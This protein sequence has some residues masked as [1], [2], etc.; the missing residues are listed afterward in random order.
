MYTRKNIASQNCKERSK[1]NSYILNLN[2]ENGEYGY[3]ICLNT[4]SKFYFDMED[5]DLIKQYCWSEHILANGYHRI[6]ARKKGTKENIKF[7]ELIGCKNYDHIDRNTLNN[8]KYNLRLYEKSQNNM[9]RSLN[10]NN[11]S[12][13]IGVCWDKNNKKW[14][15]RIGINYKNKLLGSYCNKEE[16]IKARLKAEKEYYKNFAPQRHLFEEYNI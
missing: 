14:I 1:F 8:R 9:N 4:G 2:D 15:A 11:T 6:E 10:K 13:I 3:E 12:G 16:A 5:Y 7:T